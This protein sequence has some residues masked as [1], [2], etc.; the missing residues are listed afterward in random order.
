[1]ASPLFQRLRYLLGSMS[2]EEASQKPCNITGHE[3]EHKG[4]KGYYTRGVPHFT[5]G[6]SWTVVRDDHYECGKCG[7]PDF[8]ETKVGRVKVDKE[9]DELTV[10]Q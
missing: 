5:A 9:T 2:S 3:W 6:S 7:K 8:R 10:I 1:M 4:V